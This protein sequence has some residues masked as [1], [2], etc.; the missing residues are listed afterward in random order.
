MVI[1][2]GTD[3]RSHFPA[4]VAGTI[5]R[6]LNHRFGT[7]TNMQVADTLDDE[8]KEIADQE[9]AAENAES[10][11][12]STTAATDTQQNTTA[13]VPSTSPAAQPAAKPAA[14]EGSA[15]R[16]TVKRV[17]MPIEKRTEPANSTSTSPAPAKTPEQ[18]APGQRPRRAQPDQP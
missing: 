1:T 8:E 4:A 2:Q 9:E 11:T 6:E 13:A 7:P 12:T 14:G 17:L 15:L 3:A 5:Y 18:T 10:G 16:G